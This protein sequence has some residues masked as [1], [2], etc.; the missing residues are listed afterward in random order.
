[1]ITTSANARFPGAELTVEVGGRRV[2]SEKVDLDPAKT[3]TT[4]VD[5][6]EAVRE[7]VAVV[8]TSADGRQLIRYRTDALPDANPDFEPATRPALRRLA[9]RRIDRP[10]N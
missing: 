7:P 3:L 5:L 8:V 9:V 1:M 4:I 10:C 2:R 6:S